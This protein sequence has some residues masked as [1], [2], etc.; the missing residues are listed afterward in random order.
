[1]EEEE[2]SIDNIIIN[3]KMLSQ[4]RQND[5]LYTENGKFRIDSPKLSQGILRWFNDYSREKTI[6]DI[7]VVVKHTELYISSIFENDS[8]SVEDNRMCQN[9]LLEITRAIDGLQNLKLTYNDDTFVQS[10]LDV[11]KEKFN[12]CKNNLSQK[13]EV[14]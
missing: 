4:I 3:L 13:L 8:K 10:R 6:D 9:I 1:M 12:V 5:K 2:L 14:S 7:D 11:A